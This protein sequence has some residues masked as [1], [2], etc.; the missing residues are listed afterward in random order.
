MQ[1]LDSELNS[2]NLN[3]IRNISL[4][5]SEFLGKILKWKI[6]RKNIYSNSYSNINTLND[7]TTN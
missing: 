2:K 6:L 5:N 7:I 4:S 3:F 1:E